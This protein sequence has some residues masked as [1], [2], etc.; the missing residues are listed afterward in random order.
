MKI[1]YFLIVAVLANLLLLPTTSHA[2]NYP[3]A[4]DNDLLT[5]WTSPLWYEIKPSPNPTVLVDSVPTAN[6]REL[7]AQVE[8]IIKNNP[9]KVF[10]LMNGNNV[11]YK[12]IVSP[13]TQANKFLGYSIGKTVTSMA[14]GKAICSG[15]IAMSTRAD[16]LVP[17]LQGKDLGNA[18]VK[19]LL[20]MSS[21]TVDPLFRSSYYTLDEVRSVNKG[22]KDLLD[23]LD[24]YQFQ[25][26]QFYQILL[27]VKSLFHPSSRI[28]ELRLLL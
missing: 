16:S 4:N 22:G 21:G 27:F 15:K 11:V 14:V 19:P 24:L 17:E 8:N 23:M 5:R 20:T 9:V 12:K 1:I 13:A 6:E 25:I 26:Y 7:I 3:S 10:V 28:Y 18:T 2:T